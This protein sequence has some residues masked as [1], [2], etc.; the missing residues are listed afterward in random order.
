MH[1]K[2]KKNLK[3]L[4][5]PGQVALVKQGRHW[6]LTVALPITDRMAEKLSLDFQ[7]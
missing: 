2:K 7:I 1:Q 4:T 5:D 6:V 3:P